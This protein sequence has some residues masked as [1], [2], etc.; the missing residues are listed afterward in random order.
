MIVFH[1]YAPCTNHGR[2]GFPLARE[3]TRLLVLPSESD[4]EHSLSCKEE[5]H[6]PRTSEYIPQCHGRR[7][8]PGKERFTKKPF[9]APGVRSARFRWPFPPGCSRR[10]E[11]HR[12]RATSPLAGCACATSSQGAEQWPRRPRQPVEWGAAWWTLW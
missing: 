11:C 5:L 7:L 12:C 4:R 9:N 1:R 6:P 10:R 8:H 2:R 3:T